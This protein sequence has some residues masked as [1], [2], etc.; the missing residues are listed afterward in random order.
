MDGLSQ[1]IRT[2]DKAAGTALR[3]A[4]FPKT[5]PETIP[6]SYKSRRFVNALQFVIGLE[7]ALSGKGAISCDF[8][9]GGSV[10]NY[11]SFMRMLVDSDFRAAILDGIN[12]HAVS[13]ERS[14]VLT[15]PSI[16]MKDAV[17]LYSI[18]P[19][20]YLGLPTTVREARNIVVFNQNCEVIY[21]GPLAL[22]PVSHE[23]IERD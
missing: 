5:C 6:Y 15:L 10:A 7:L 9:N 20:K 4:A 21:V 2:G 3:G 8:P 12:P 17:Y 22:R 16:R 13:R 11:P 1:E 14:R 19:R 23:R 18:R